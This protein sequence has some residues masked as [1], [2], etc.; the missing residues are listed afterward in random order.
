MEISHASYT[1]LTETPKFDEYDDVNG[2]IICKF[3]PN[4][5]IIGL[6]KKKY[7]KSKINFMSI[8]TKIVKINILLDLN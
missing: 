1:V 2:I 5:Y 6:Y 8:K 7:V 3:Y 4:R